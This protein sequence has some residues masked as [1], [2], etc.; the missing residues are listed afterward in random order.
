PTAPRPQTALR[1]ATLLAGGPPHANRFPGKRGHD[2][3]AA[4]LVEVANFDMITSTAGGAFSKLRV[5]P[6]EGS[7][8]SVTQDQ[9]L[10]VAGQR[11]Q[12][13]PAVPVQIPRGQR[14]DALRPTHHV[15]GAPFS[16]AVGAGQHQVD[17]RTPLLPLVGTVSDGEVIVTIAV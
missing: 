11:N 15:E 4:V 5:F 7:V 12:V 14:R 9:H 3:R 17:A 1:R 2:V 16:G 10:A 13:R 6:G 8:A